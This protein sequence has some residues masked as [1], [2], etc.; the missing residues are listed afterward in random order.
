MG[1]HSA[2]CFTSMGLSVIS[3][4]NTRSSAENITS[5]KYTGVHYLAPPPLYASLQMIIPNEV[6]LRF[7]LPLLQPFVM[8]VSSKTSALSDASLRLLTQIMLG[9]P[10]KK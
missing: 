1:S 8:D 5:E 6:L 7:L 2:S 9:A 4:S 10:W 3:K